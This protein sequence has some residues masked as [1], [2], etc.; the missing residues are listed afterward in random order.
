MNLL[1]KL[2]FTL[3]ISLSVLSLKAQNT[4]EHLTNLNDITK[5][6]VDKDKSV[7]AG[8]TSGYILH[9]TNEGK[10]I[11]QF[12]L[13]DSKVTGLVQCKDGLLLATTYNKL[14]TFKDGKW[15]ISLFLGK[16]ND[17][18]QKILFEDNK[19]DVY[20]QLYGDYIYKREN[21]L[22]NKVSELYTLSRRVIFVS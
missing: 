19:K 17:D 22:W 9:F 5:V 2:F 3:I 7:W 14:Y 4:V 6:L 18:L 11:E 16:P 20:V 8:N 10:Q 1:K 13:E 12:F 15:A 21:N